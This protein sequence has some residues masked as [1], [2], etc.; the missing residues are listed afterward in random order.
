MTEAG[1]ELNR[2]LSAF[3]Q[4]LRGIVE[5]ADLPEEVVA[6]CGEVLRI[7]AGLQDTI[8]RWQASRGE[9][10]VFILFFNFFLN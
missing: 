7:S 9:V 3:Q 5:S 2:L 10:R 8:K 4:D 6:Q 1:P